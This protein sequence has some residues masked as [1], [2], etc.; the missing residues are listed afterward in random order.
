MTVRNFSLEPFRS[1]GVLPDLLITGSIARC[2]NTL[3]IDYRLYGH[4]ERVAIPS[5]ANIPARRHGLW[6]ETCMEFFLGIKNSPGYW[7][8]NLSPAGHWNVY[9]FSAYRQGMQEE[10]AFREL[11]FS[12]RS[13]RDSLSLA[14]AFPLG[15]IV[16]VGQPLEAGISA[17]IK[18]RGGEATL[19]ALIH[20]GP[21][22]DFHRR[23]GFALEL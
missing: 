23:D 6:Q 5:P 7:E 15:P 13:R 21:Q 4:L 17:V 16:E 3:V 1:T 9:R 19:W 11:P 20:P 10:M 22:A 18:D 12:V 2:A 8:F 14:L